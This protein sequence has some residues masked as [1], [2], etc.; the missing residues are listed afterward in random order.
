MK[1][2]TNEKYYDEIKPKLE[3]LEDLKRNAT[4]IGQKVVGESLFKQDL[5]F[6]FCFGSFCKID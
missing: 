6:L 5:F 2:M 3:S 4:E 1:N